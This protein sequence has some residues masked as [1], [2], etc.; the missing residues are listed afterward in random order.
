M[1]IVDQ[2]SAN[3]LRLYQGWASLSLATYLVI[4]VKSFGSHSILT[5]FRESKATV[6]QYSHFNLPKN[7]SLSTAQARNQRQ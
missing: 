3:K 4:S 7:A 5:S 2:K 6:R 1:R